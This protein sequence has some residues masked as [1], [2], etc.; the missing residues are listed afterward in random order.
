MLYDTMVAM[1][2]VS[3][4]GCKHCMVNQA[5]NCHSGIATGSAT[6]QPEIMQ[7]DENM[8]QPVPRRDAACV[9]MKTSR[10]DC[11]R[12]DVRSSECVDSDDEDV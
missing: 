8:Q 4:I 5:T 7:G 3:V 9:L 1:Y 12:Q 10:A 11:S 6:G 2:I